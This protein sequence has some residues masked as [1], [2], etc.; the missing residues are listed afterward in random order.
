MVLAIPDLCSLV[1]I[2]LGYLVC[3]RSTKA[4]LHPGT[5]VICHRSRHA[6][7]SWVP[8]K[9]IAPLSIFSNYLN[10]IYSIWYRIFDSWVSTQLSE[11]RGKTKRSQVSVEKLDQMCDYKNVSVATRSLTRLITT[12]TI[13]VIC[14]KRRE[15]VVM[16]VICMMAYNLTVA[17]WLI[18]KW[19]VQCLC[20]VGARIDQ[21]KLLHHDNYYSKTGCI[22][23]TSDILYIL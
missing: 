8:Y 15:C 20:A 6:P 23:F 12:F 22:N 1:Y 2:V 13:G 11:D 18:Y 19:L 21:N 9:V 5:R 10:L 3:S 16:G 4:R 14:M 17:Y 7:H